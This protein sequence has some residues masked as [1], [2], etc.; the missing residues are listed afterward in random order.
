MHA[1]DSCNVSTFK[2]FNVSRDWTDDY[3]IVPC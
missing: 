3:L 1:W 2:R